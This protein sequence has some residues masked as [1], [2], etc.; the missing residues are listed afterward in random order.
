[1][2]RSTTLFLTYLFGPFGLELNRDEKCDGS[3]ARG[4]GHEARRKTFLLVTP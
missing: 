2:D 1:M 4:E 3:Q